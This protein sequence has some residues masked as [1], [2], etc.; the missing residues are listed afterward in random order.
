MAL[1]LMLGISAYLLLECTG[2]AAAASDSFAPSAADTVASH[3]QFEAI[4]THLDL[5]AAVE[6]ALQEIANSP[7]SAPRIAAQ[8][9][10]AEMP[11]DEASPCVDFQ[12]IDTATH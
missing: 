2:A 11:W 9:G 12:S 8:P 4:E 10:V 1:C 7:P 5:M 6:A 3:A